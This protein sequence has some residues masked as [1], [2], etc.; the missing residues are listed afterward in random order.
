MLPS[1]LVVVE[2]TPI[3]DLITASLA[4]AGFAAV[5]AADAAE[6]DSLLSQFLPDAAVI[7]VTAE[8]ESDPVAFTPLRKLLHVVSSSVLLTQD[9]MTLCGPDG[10][11]C[12]A[13]LCMD[14]PFQPQVLVDA[15][16]RIVNASQGD[17]KE[18]LRCGPLVLSP[19]HL[20][21][22]IK[23]SGGTRD[24]HLRPLE[25]R[26][27][28]FLMSQPS[29]IHTR[30]A[31]LRAVWGRSEA[32]ARIVDQAVR[33]VR[34]ELERFDQEELLQTVAGAGYRLASH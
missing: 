31:L 17:A 12:G 1:I 6:A 25:F 5:G 7:D 10:Q 9:C 14:K 22:G 19:R 8:A 23:H 21:A 34:K 16:A 32:N 11:A 30:D 20:K 27:L 13:S 28:R 2:A 33:R 26:L 4:G 15:V 3:R 29:E 18:T 24:L